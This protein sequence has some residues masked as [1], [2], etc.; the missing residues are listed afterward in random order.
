MELPD[1]LQ[2]VI[3]LFRA[4]GKIPRHPD[5]SYQEAS[6]VAIFIGN[7]FLPER[8]D[9]LVDSVPVDQLRQA[10]AQRRSELARIAEGMPSHQSFIERFAQAKAA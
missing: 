6:W 3:D 1:S 7:R 8:Y 2:H 5:E 10:M 9:A 4:S